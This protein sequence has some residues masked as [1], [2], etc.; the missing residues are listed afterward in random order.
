M[1]RELNILALLKGEE[2]YVFV[3]H[4]EARAEVVQ[5][6]RDWASDPRLSFSWF[7]AAVLAQRVYKPLQDSSLPD[8]QRSIRS[9]RF[10]SCDH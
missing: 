10:D 9:Q 7:D 6:M 5:V 8:K 1:L 3:Y 2:H 4:D